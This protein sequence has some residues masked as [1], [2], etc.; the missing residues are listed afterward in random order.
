M[1]SGR[2]RRRPPA[3]YA[4]EQLSDEWVPLSEP[5]G[6]WLNRRRRQV[7]RRGEP[8]SLTPTEY[9]LLLLLR[10]YGGQVLPFEQIASAVW[11]DGAAVN[12]AMLDRHLH[13]LRDK[14]GDRDQRL[15]AC[16]RG[17]GWVGHFPRPGPER[18]AAR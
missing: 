14:L 13:G 17:F 3:D 16:R 9:D 4:I 1:G 15:I 2:L 12:R 6:L 18:R 10:R 8:L 7:T 11:A 5:N